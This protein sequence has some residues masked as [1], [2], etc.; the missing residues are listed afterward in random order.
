LW[1]HAI[2]SVGRAFDVAGAAVIAARQA[3]KKQIKKQ[4]K[5][6]QGNGS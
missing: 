2:F 5:Y 3:D 1:T 4:I 6:N